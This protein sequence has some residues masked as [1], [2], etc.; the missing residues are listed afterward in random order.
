MS[1]RDHE[2]I[3]RP[4]P[5]M[6]EAAHPKEGE[7]LPPTLAGELGARF[8]ADFQHV[9][10]HHDAAAARAAQVMGAQ[11]FTRGNDIT[12]APGRYNPAS[13]AGR[14]LLAH[15][16]AHVLQQRG[17]GQTTDAESRADHA[18][19]AVAAGRYVSPS[20]LGS[21]PLGVQTKP[22]DGPAPDVETK[23]EAETQ[24]KKEGEEGAGRTF[25]TFSKVLDNFALDKDTLTAQ[26]LKD[27]DSTAFSIGLGTGMLRRGKAKIEIVGHADTTGKDP[28]NEELGQKRADRVK[29]ALEKKLQ[30]REGE[31]PLVLE[32][33]VRSAGEKELLI[34][35]KD[36]TLEPRNRAVEIRVTIEMMPEE[37]KPEPLPG[38][39]PH[40]YPFP[41]PEPSPTPR[42]PEED[43]WK[44]MEDQ[45]KRIEELDKKLQRKPK[46]AQD[47]V[48]D[49]VME[50]V[51][52]PILKELPLSKEKKK[53]LREKIRD[54][55][56]AGTEKG[57][58][59][60]VDASGATG[61]EAEAL[62]AACKAAIKEKGEKK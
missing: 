3:R 37:K 7:P 41:W 62:K 24:T 20:A 28:H 39:D 48:V 17:A 15:E 21:A 40:K 47:V 18:G 34:P 43:L 58:E 36:N 50:N 33:S 60:A 22:G 35:T 14:E 56:E 12:F 38:I 1:S 46:S 54:G 23:P 32:W 29:A 31:K 4:V 5:V 52:D 30:A 25:Q 44:K 57:C 42:R 26:H 2:T 10:V 16:L 45:R 55:V 6:A 9:R 53:W 27:I 19:S 8:G 51:I 61:D 59:A 11:A 13:S 49:A